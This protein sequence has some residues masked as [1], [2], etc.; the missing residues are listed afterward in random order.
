MLARNQRR[1]AREQ[2]KEEL[3]TDYAQ[4]AEEFARKTTEGILGAIDR[5]LGDIARPRSGEEAQG[6]EIELGDVTIRAEDLARRAQAGIRKA[7]EERG[8][9]ADDT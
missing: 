7:L 4:R 8:W 1:L 3:A 9:S 2:R 6:A 5:K